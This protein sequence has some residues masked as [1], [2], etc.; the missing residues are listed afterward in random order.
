M[1]RGRAPRASASASGQRSAGARP[2]AVQNP[3]RRALHSGPS[4][5]PLQPTLPLAHPDLAPPQEE[6][7]APN[8]Q[9]AINSTSAAVS[10]HTPKLDDKAFACDTAAGRG[11]RLSPLS[12]PLGPVC[13]G[14]L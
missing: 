14:M 11:K 2:Q 7:L 4:R 5:P 8:L 6:Y 13:L 3:L 1:G 10:M 9:E 12:I